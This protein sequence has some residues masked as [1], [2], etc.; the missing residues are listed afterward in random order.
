MADPKRELKWNLV[1]G[2]SS[3]SLLSISIVIATEGTRSGMREGSGLRKQ[4]HERQETIIYS[5]PTIERF[6]EQY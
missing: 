3:H 5:F 4:S 2:L 6:Y 1:S